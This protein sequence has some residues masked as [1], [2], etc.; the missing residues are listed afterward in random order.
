MVPAAGPDPAPE[1][2]LTEG[3][4]VRQYAKDGEGLLLMERRLGEQQAALV[5]H[6]EAGTASLLE[7]RG[8]Y[9]LIAGREFSGT[10]GAYESAV[11]VE[12]G[13]GQE[14]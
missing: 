11:L 8:K 2:V 6:T 13:S 10:L 4:L 1:P 14:A 5:F 9:D 3:T 7:L 12:A